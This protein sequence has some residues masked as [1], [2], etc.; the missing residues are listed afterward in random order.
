MG[1]ILLAAMMLAVFAFGYF[2]VDRFEKFMDKNFRDCHESRDRGRKVYVA[3]TEGKSAEA[4][5]KE[6]NAML[7]SLPDGNEYEIIICKTV[8]PRIIECLEESGR[9]VEYDF[10]Q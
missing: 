6:V 1:D 4:V 5:S 9:A 3:E 8:D 10:R 7:D 2:V